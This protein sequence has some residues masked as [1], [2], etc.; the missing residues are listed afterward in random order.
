MLS[1][2]HPETIDAMAKQMNAQIGTIT[3]AAA[4]RE[5]IL[6]AIPFG[7]VPDVA[8]QVGSLQ[9]KI[10]IDATNPFPQRDGDITKRV[11]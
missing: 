2:R 6:L 5:V 11:I 8:Q 9:N 4:F 3:A 7:Q 10:L 1:S